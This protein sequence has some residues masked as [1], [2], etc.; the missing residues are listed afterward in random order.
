MPAFNVLVG[1]HVKPCFLGIT[2]TP[3][4]GW[5]WHPWSP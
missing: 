1:S 3:D 4:L 2:C 5:L